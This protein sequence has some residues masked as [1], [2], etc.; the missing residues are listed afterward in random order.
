MVMDA[1]NHM[2][3]Y[4]TISTWDRNSGLA[5]NQD[6]MMLPASADGYSFTPFVFLDDEIETDSF[7]VAGGT[8]HVQ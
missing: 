3:T 5:S 1:I 4:E 6:E 2:L 8:I 7:C